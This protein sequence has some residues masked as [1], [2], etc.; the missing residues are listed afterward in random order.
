MDSDKAKIY[1]LSPQ[2]DASISLPAVEELCCDIKIEIIEI[3]R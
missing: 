1:A 3:I 2:K